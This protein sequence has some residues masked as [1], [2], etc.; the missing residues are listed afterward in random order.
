[1]VVKK[2]PDILGVVDIPMAVDIPVAVFKNTDILAVIKSSK[3]VI[4][5]CRHT[6]SCETNNCVII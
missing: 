2:C 3:H 6:G 4:R 5:P 1:M